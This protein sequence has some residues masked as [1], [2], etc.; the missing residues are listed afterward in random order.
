VVAQCFLTGGVEYSLFEILRAV[1]VQARRAELISSHGRKPVE[2]GHPHSMSLFFVGALAGRLNAVSVAPPGL[3]QK[4]KWNGRVSLRP[5]GLR[6]VARN[7]SRPSGAAGGFAIYVTLRDVSPPAPTGQQVEDAGVF[8][9]HGF[10]FRYQ[11]TV[12]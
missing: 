12:V 1:A 8:H 7:Q 3:K 11:T 6:T 2:S 10:G 5:T 4:K 9:K